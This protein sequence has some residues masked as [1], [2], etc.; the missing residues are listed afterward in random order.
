MSD[1]LIVE[2]LAEEKITMHYLFL[3]TSLVV[4]LILVVGGLILSNKVA[5]PIYRLNKHMNQI[6]DGE[7]DRPVNFRKGDFFP[8]LAVAFNRVLAKLKSK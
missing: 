1:P 3:G 8:E 6:S 4:T 5:G 7:I 2:M